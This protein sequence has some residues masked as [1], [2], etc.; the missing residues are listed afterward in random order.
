M[1]YFLRRKAEG[2]KSRLIEREEVKPNWLNVLYILRHELALIIGT[3]DAV[4]KI[5]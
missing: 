4:A 2:D 1:F 5:E 3:K